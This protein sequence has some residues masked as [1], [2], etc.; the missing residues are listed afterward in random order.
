MC[1]FTFFMCHTLHVGARALGLAVEATCARPRP[2]A[3][4]TP[5][6]A[7]FP[8]FSNAARSVHLGVHTHPQTVNK[9]HCIPRMQRAAVN[10]LRRNI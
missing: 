8:D 5:S 1:C 9:S 4:P 7:H 10:K 2:A 6:T 3:Q